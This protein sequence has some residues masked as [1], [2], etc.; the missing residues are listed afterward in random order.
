MIIITSRT[1]TRHRKFRAFS[2]QPYASDPNELY[3]AE[4]TKLGHHRRYE[5][6]SD[7]F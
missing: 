2:N 6:I 3:L 7:R 1:L 5:P 4:V